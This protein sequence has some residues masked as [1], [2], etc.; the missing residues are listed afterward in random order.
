MPLDYIKMGEKR[1]LQDGTLVE[2]TEEGI[3][4][5]NEETI[6]VYIPPKEYHKVLPTDLTKKE[7]KLIQKIMRPDQ[8]SQEGFLDNKEKL[9]DVY[10]RDKKTLEDYDI[11][12]EE[13]H[14]KLK[15]FFD[16]VREGYKNCE[17][18]LEVDSFP[19]KTKRYGDKYMASVVKYWGDQQCPFEE[20]EAYSDFKQG[21]GSI[22]VTIYNTANN[23][24]IFFSELHLHL[25]KYHN[26]FEGNTAYRLDPIDVIKCLEIAEVREFDIQVK[27][28]IDLE[29]E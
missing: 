3:I 6:K 21:E 19:I 24:K 7:L 9:I 20:L 8:I 29:L 10:L 15:D 2:R 4:V 14:D 28:K 27:P 22:D 12:F 18:V 26:F 13:I 1:R 5:H 25:I 17:N 11:T 23:T 16:S